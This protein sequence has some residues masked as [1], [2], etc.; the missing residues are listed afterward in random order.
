MRLR[1][2]LILLLLAAIPVALG[3]LLAGGGS[4]HKPPRG[5][6][7]AQISLHLGDGQPD[8]ALLACG[9]THHYTAY[10][11]GTTIR[12]RGTISS[13][14]RSAVK[15]KL[16]A[17]TAGA[18]RPSG[19]AA[20]EVRRSDT[21]KGS[22]PAPTPGTYFARAELKLSGALVARSDKHYFEVR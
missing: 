2:L 12:F 18:F 14:A 3:L 11:A 5:L 22:F 4:D 9:V 13:H 17:C 1:H 19:D 20:A 21:Y 16:K 7:L 6:P 8:R 15:L 10:R